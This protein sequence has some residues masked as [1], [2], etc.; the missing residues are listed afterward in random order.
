MEIE[1]L[2]TRAENSLEYFLNKSVIEVLK[3]LDPDAMRPK[4]LVK[5]ISESIQVHTMLQDAKTRN[6]IIRAMP[7]TEAEKFAKF[8]GI[9]E[10]DDVYYKLTH[11]KFTKS[12]MKKSLEFFGKEFD[13][14]SSNVKKEHEEISPERFLFQH[15]ID[16]VQKIRKKLDEPPHKALLHMPTGSGKTISA[17]RVILTHLLEN[18]STLVIW[19]A[20]NEEL[21]EQAM[22]E[23]QR[24][25][26][27]AG[28]RKINTYRFFS[29]NN[30]NLLE[31]DSGFVSAGLLKMLGSAKKS[32]TFLS[33]VAQKTSLVVID[34]AHQA[35]A[36][37]FS[38]IIEELASNKN[39]KLL[40]LSA[41]PGRKSDTMDAANVQLVRFFENRKIILDTRNENPVTFLIKRGYLAKPKFNKIK[42]LGGKLSSIDIKR[43]ERETDVPKFILEKLSDDAR[44][45]L[46]IVNEV[47]RL[48]QIHKKIIV[49]AS[50]VEHARSISLI[51]S[52][53][54]Y[55]SHY[56]NSKT[57]SGI[58]AEILR[59]YKETDESTILCNYGILTTGFDAPKTSS[60]VIARPTKSHVLYAQMVGR[61]MRGPKAG[62]NRICEISTIMDSDISDF[63]N[64]TEIFTQWELIWNV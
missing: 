13:E 59:K 9:K 32:V 60:V 5:L 26:K 29:N 61:G 24:V 63:V 44:R 39:T 64:I 53:K 10:W 35:T 52:A 28:D 62:G 33:K 4:N 47:M 3:I 30:V 6:I 57:P 23:F 43:L 16:T 22:N 37:K 12:T 56:I 58:R 7:K 14:E 42:Y 55:N 48:A 21:C 49:F 17:M 2:L 46:G 11:A 41:T 54:K 34:E 15:Q 19:L 50:T 18:P 51:L 27:A 40:G 20:Y 36:E 45:N 8:I 1:T 25:W 31:V 38:I